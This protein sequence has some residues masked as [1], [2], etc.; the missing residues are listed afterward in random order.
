M[1]QEAH[2]DLGFLGKLAPQVVIDLGGDGGRWA[3]LK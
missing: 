2:R 1:P 3:C